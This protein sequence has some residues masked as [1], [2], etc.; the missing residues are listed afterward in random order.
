MYMALHIA[1]PEVSRLAADL[2]KFEKTTKT[3]AVRRVLR[4]AVKRHEADERVS[5]FRRVATAIAEEARRQKI[6]PVTKKEF[7]NLW[8]MDELLR[9][10]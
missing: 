3:E 8:G 7:D 10:R 5:R 4:E 1:D 9:D 2:A 6:K